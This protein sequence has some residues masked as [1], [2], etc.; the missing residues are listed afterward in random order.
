MGINKMK[1]L[2][3]KAVIYIVLTA[4]SACAF[5]V[6]AAYFVDRPAKL[7]IIHDPDWY[8]S[9]PD[10]MKSDAIKCEKRIAEISIKNCENIGAAEEKTSA[11]IL[12]KINNGH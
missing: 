5:A 4:I 2:P 11:R 3:Q 6:T 9:H 1:F 10:T 12:N 7:E 8:I